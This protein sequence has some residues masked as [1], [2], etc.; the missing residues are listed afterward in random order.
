[1]APLAP[2]GRGR[3]REGVDAA[4]WIPRVGRPGA[5][6]RARAYARTAAQARPGVPGRA[7]RPSLP[8]Q[9]P[10]ARL[11]PRPRRPP[12]APR[13]QLHAEQLTDPRYH[14][15]GRERVPAQ[16]DAAFLHPHALQAQHLRPEPRQ[17][18]LREGA[19]C[20]VLLLRR[21]GFRRRQCPAV[22]LIRSRSAA[23]GPAPRT[24]GACP[25]ARA[26]A[27]GPPR[28]GD[29]YE[30]SRADP[31]RRPAGS[32]DAPMR[33]DLRLWSVGTDVLRV[34]HAG[35]KGALQGYVS[36]HPRLAARPRSV[37]CWPGPAPLVG[38]APR[39][40]SAAG[41]QTPADPARKVVFV[42]RCRIT[43]TKPRSGKR[44]GLTRSQRRERS[45]FHRSSDLRRTGRNLEEWQEKT[46]FT[47]LTPCDTRWLDS[48]CTGSES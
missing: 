7:G 25:P 11:A 32:V 23:A 28:D 4:G 45:C 42:S 6:V 17:H 14:P 39:A 44:P 47:P 19:R 24:K 37:K 29:G 3:A 12:R 35:R 16:V 46:P 18:L 36:R 8:G 20:Y 21:C 5:G 15:R 43:L 33:T 34:L 38:V 41:I 13:R 31:R 22:H 2:G 10:Q 48:V 26:P 40:R 30:K 1:M 27:P 9:G